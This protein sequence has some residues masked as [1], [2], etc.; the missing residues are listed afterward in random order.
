MSILARPLLRLWRRIGLRLPFDRPKIDPTATADRVLRAIINCDVETIKDV[1]SPSVEC[2]PKIQGQLPE[3]DG[4][5]QFARAFRSRTVASANTG[6]ID[7]QSTVREPGKNGTVCVD[8]RIRVARLANKNPPAQARANTFGDVEDH[9]AGNVK[10]ESIVDAREMIEPEHSLYQWRLIFSPKGPL[11]GLCLSDVASSQD[12]PSALTE[13]DCYHSSWDATCN[14]IGDFMHVVG[15]L[16]ALIVAI[17]LLGFLLLWPQQSREALRVV[18]E[19]L[20]SL[21]TTVPWDLVI[22]AV[23]FGSV[24]YIFGFIALTTRRRNEP[25]APIS[26][27]RWNMRLL[28][29]AFI[30]LCFYAV[31]AFTAYAARLPS[32]AAVPGEQ[33]SPIPA[34]TPPAINSALFWFAVIALVSGAATLLLLHFLARR[35]AFRAIR[36]R[37]SVSYDGTSQLMLVVTSLTVL[38]VVLLWR[39]TGVPAVAI[40]W[41][42][43]AL[44]VLSLLALLA[45]RTRIPWLAIIITF[46]LVLGAANLDNHAL[47]LT[48]KSSSLPLD[49]KSAFLAWVAKRAPSAEKPLPAFIVTA[50]GG[51]IRA[52]VMTSIVLDQLSAR[53][54]QF[55]DRIFAIIGVSGGSVGATTFATAAAHGWAGKYPS[56]NVPDWKEAL[57][58]DLLAPTVRAFLSTTIWTQYVPQRWMDLSA[59]DRSRALEAAWSDGWQATTNTSSLG[60]FW[61]SDLLKKDVPNLLLMTTS[62]EDGEPMAISHLCNFGVRTLN[63][64]R[65]GID[66]PLKTAGIMSAR[67]PFISSTAHV[68]GGIPVADFVDG[69]YF[70]NSGVTAATRLIQTLRGGDANA[71]TPTGCT[72][73]PLKP[74]IAARDDARL[75]NTSIVVIRIRNGSK[76]DTAKQ[77]M[78]YGL[79]S[80]LTAMSAAGDA[81]ASEAIRALDELV[82]NSP[83]ECAKRVGCMVVKQITFSLSPSSIPLP[84]G[85][86]L[87]SK[88]RDVIVEQLETSP[89]NKKAFDFVDN[90]LNNKPIMETACSA[91]ST[92]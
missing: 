82:R 84:L 35:I 2:S 64:V 16:R 17:A 80:Q 90:T 21:K 48:K 76:D 26:A 32:D 40:V 61:F 20:I 33:V 63:D 66:I 29:L 67:F 39:S 68:P 79:S 77:S 88:A 74:I 10:A 13:S 4:L 27:G 71:A 43:G 31:L 50:D 38:G 8:S 30:V 22:S 92:D 15:K 62:V 19:N 23:I 11:I 7:I 3:L 6:D 25:A 53:N 24:G 56:P 87:S 9:G 42:T 75:A 36:L 60:D 14:A 55:A 52:A 45:T 72:C 65:P 57:L 69:G 47:I 12:Y 85:W 78:F 86:Q 46:P 70:E 54:P 41:A 18:F 5:L 89:C 1:T 44:A 73:G 91:W 81:R 34:V 37:P 83:A 58:T 28:V 51:G 59:W 49:A